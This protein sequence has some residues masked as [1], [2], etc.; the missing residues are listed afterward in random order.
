ML[1]WNV[2]QWG[3]ELGLWFH[4]LD[5]GLVW[6]SVTRMRSWIWGSRFCSK[7]PS[8]IRCS[9]DWVLFVVLVQAAKE[10]VLEV[11]REKDGDFRSGRSDF[12]GRLGGT[13]LDVSWKTNT[14]CFLLLS[15]PLTRV[16]SDLFSGSGS[17]VCCRNRD[18]QKRRNDQEDSKRCRSPNPV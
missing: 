16:R 4:V 11:I 9:S 7:V 17:Q 2:L 14:T 13:N 18:R 3:G 15:E 10:L 6:G 1:I 5:Q 12:G 8:Q